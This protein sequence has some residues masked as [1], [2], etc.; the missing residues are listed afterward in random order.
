MKKFKDID[1]Y[2]HAFPK[3]HQKRLKEMRAIIRKAAPKAKEGISYGMP[4]LHQKGYVVYFG[5]FKDHIS[6]FP[7]SSGI[8]VF[9]KQL[10]AYRTS[11]GTLQFPLNKKLPVGLIR[12]IVIFRAKEN[13]QRAAGKKASPY[14]TKDSL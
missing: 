7:A 13:A 14:R 3:D 4:A 2:I 10:S 8:A 11:K 1:S 12:K 5:G 6:L 9:K